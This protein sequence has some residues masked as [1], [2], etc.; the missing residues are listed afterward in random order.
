MERKRCWL[1]C[2][3]WSRSEWRVA[4]FPG[5]C[6]REKELPTLDTARIIIPVLSRDKLHR[7]RRAEVRSPLSRD[8]SVSPTFIFVNQIKKIYNERSGCGG[9]FVDKLQYHV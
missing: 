4:R 8:T 1:G 6:E 7:A 5:V 9:S 3:V 2:G